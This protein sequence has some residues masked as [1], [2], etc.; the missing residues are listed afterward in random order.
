MVAVAL[1]ARLTTIG[2]GLPYELDPDERDFVEH[3]W[4]MIEDGRFDPQ[5]YGHPAATLMG[6]LAFLYAIYG[7]VGTALGAFDG[8]AAVGDAYRAD[9]TQLFLI[10]R[11]VSVVSGVAVV[12]LVYAIGRELRM[13]AVWAALAALLVALS[14]PMI[15]FSSI[16]RSDIPMVALMLAVVL[17]SLRILDRPSGRSFLVAGALLGLCVTTKYPGLLAAVP[18]FYANLVVVAERRTDRGLLWLAGAAVASVVVAFI[19]APY[20]FLNPATRSRS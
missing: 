11:L 18:I 16:V 1:V 7:A 12:A 4:R 2:Y 3:A 13:R 15:H 6:I 14:I 20:L 17:V 10:G 5:W 8:M 9:V 19:V